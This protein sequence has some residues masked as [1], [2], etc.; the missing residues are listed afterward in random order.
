MAEIKFNPKKLAKLNN[1]ARLVSQNPDV[2]WP[3]LKL[4]DP[5][6]IFDIGCGTGFFSVEFLKRAPNAKVIG[7]DIA[8]VMLQWIEENRPEFKQGKLVTLLM[9]ED[10]LPLDPATGDLATMINLHHELHNPAGLLGEIRIAL[11]P[12]GTLMILDWKA[13]ETA[14]GPPIEIRISQETVFAQLT[15]A[16]FE[17]LTGHE[18]FEDFFL[19]TAK[20]PK[21]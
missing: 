16:G 1:P 21:A 17:E 6:L 11:K 18:V 15:E 19:I 2:F 10:K 4:D 20:R 14:S 3:L 5:Q 7:L 12:G 13:K 8:E 9:P